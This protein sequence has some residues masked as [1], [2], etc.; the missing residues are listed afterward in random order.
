MQ[1]SYGSTGEESYH[2]YPIS[3]KQDYDWYFINERTS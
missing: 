1:L 2:V 3:L